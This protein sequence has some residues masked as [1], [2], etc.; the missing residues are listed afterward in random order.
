MLYYI[1]TE[2]STTAYINPHIGHVVASNSGAGTYG[3]PEDFVGREK[4]PSY[5]RDEPGSW[6]SL[7]LGSTRRLQVKHYCLRHGHMI[8]PICVLQNWNVNWVL[9]RQHINHTTMGSG[10]Y[11]EGHWIVSNAASCEFYRYFR[12]IKTG[13]NTGLPSNCYNFLSCY[14]FPNDMKQVSF[15]YSQVLLC[16]SKSIKQ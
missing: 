3:I 13:P 7:D 9:L 11:S 8:N 15:S 12:I 16:S 5:S 2:G 6:M 4:K 1:G 10:A 14:N